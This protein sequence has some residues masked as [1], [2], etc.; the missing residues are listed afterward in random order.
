MDK[1]SFTWLV[2]PISR[3]VIC[4]GSFTGPRWSRGFNR[5]KTTALGEAKAKLTNFTPVTFHTELEAPSA[6]V[7]WL[8][9]SVAFVVLLRLL[10]PGVWVTAIIKPWSSSGIK[11][12][13]VLCT[14]IQ[15]PAATISSPIIGTHLYRIRNFRLLIYRSVMAEK[16]ALKAPKNRAASPFLRPPSS[17]C[18]L[19]RNKAHKPGLRV[20]ALTAEIRMAV[21]RGNANCL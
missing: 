12:E 4:A 2:S 10:P 17:A 7:I 8:I 11:P 14:S 21:A 5:Q 18:G 19:R 3:P 9:A 13:G 20:R 15:A 6:S 16:A 1:A